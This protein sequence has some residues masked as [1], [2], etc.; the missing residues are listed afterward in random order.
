MSI[1]KVDTINEKTTGNGV[2]IAHAL[3]GSGIAGHVIQ[4]VESS[5]ATETL[6]ATSS[7]NVTTLNCAITPKQT[8]SKL[9]VTVA[10]NVGGDEGGAEGVGCKLTRQVAGGSFANADNINTSAWGCHASTNAPT[11]DFYAPA[12]V[13]F[14]VYD[15]PT[16]T[17]G[18]TLTYRLEIRGYASTYPIGY[19]RGRGFDSD[20]SGRWQTA[21]TISI[22]E[23]AQ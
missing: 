15:D 10:T 20:G 16:F 13:T 12:N 6:F 14:Q 4:V 3:K 21:S 19:N 22:Q 2:E 23:I 8:S 7:W 1:L 5:D 17:L 18:Q 9:L 11:G